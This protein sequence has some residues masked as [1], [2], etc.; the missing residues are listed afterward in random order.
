MAIDSGLC[1]VDQ[2][3]KEAGMQDETGT[4]DHTV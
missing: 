2:P 3:A 1:Y 4:W